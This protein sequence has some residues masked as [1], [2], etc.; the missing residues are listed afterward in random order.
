MLLGLPVLMFLSMLYLGKT[1]N[2]KISRKWNLLF[3]PAAACILGVFTNDIH[4]F[5]FKLEPSV[6]AWN[7]KYSYGPLY[8]IIAAMF[9]VSVIA[10]LFMDASCGNNARCNILG[11]LRKNRQRKGSAS[12]N[13]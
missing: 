6:E 10:I 8:Y 2:Y 9:G 13:V 1:D 4:Q 5:A 3:I 7:G 11:R 12:E